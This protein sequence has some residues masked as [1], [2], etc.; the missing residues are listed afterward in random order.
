LDSLLS[1]QALAGAYLKYMFF[2]SDIPP[3]LKVSCQSRLQ[4]R[5][6]KRM[7]PF[8]SFTLSELSLGI[9]HQGARGPWFLDSTEADCRVFH[10]VDHTQTDGSK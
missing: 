7:P 10:S 2:H 8:N 4:V 1:F 6:K 5:F 3:N 9:G